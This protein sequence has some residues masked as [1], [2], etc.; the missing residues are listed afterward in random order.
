MMEVRTILSL[1]D[2]GGIA[3]PEFQ[4]GFVWNRAQVRGLMDSLYR[5]HPVGSLLMWTTRT[6]VAAQRGDAPQTL[7]R[8]Q[9]LLDGQQRITSLYGI[10]KGTPPPF[11]EGNKNAFTDL[12]FN[13]ETETFEFYGPVRM[14]DNPLWISVTSLMQ[15]GLTLLLATIF[16]DENLKPHAEVYVERLNR[17]LQIETIDLHIEDV[18]DEDMTVDTVVDIFNRVNSGGTKLS[19]GDLALAKVCAEWPEARGEF[20]SRLRKWRRAGYSFTLE[21]ILRGINALTTGSAMFSAL[22]DVNAAEIHSGLLKS[23]GHIDYLLNLISSRLGLDHNRVLGS[24]YAFPVMVSYIEGRGRGS[25]EQR[26]CDRLL[27]WFIHTLLWGRYSSSTETVLN[28]DL[29]SIEDAGDGLGRLIERLRRDRGNLRI[30]P[31]DFTGA[32]IGAR[33]Y[34][35]LYMLTR[36]H[37]ARDWDTGIEL[38]NEMLGKLS[39]LQMHHIFPKSKLYCHGYQRSQVNALA[40]FTFLTQETNL[41]VSNRDP[42]EYISQFQT[43]QPGAVESHWIPM[44]PELWK[45]EN[46]PDFLAARRQLLAQAANEFLDNLL[47]G[48][49]RE[50]APVQAVTDLIEGPLGGVV[51]EEEE[52]ILLDTNIWVIDQGLPEGE[53]SYELV[54]ETTSLPIVVLDL[55]WPD[56]IQAG[57][58]QPVA[59]LIDEDAEVE[60]LASQAGFGLYTDV[61]SLK[62]YINQE[63][64]AI[65]AAAD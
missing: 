45:Y 7:G 16:S 57:F 24:R 48:A 27:F 61:D 40:N 28:Q 63:I 4:R 46:Y 58:S 23:E 31:Q 8:V 15:S 51:S 29:Q 44:D 21:W 33:F 30:A 65:D 42:E 36:I 62:R 25:L 19:K 47:H 35:L 13:M 49:I 37:H 2:L 3:L 43:R 17:I 55:A 11:F 26:E 52:Q 12:Y 54:N 32:T 1:I 20:N 41:L 9:L 56:G 38:S 39:R 53:L 60:A 59:L 18:T 34:P 64:L 10:I 5:R 22:H 6:G 50:V 14:R